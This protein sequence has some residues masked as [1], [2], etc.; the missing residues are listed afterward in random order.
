MRPKIKQIK[1]IKI[2]KNWLVEK[3]YCYNFNFYIFKTNIKIFKVIII[4]LVTNCIKFSCICPGLVEWPQMQ[5]NFLLSNS[6]R[7]KLSYILYQ[8]QSFGPKVSI[9]T[10]AC[11]IMIRA[12]DSLIKGVGWQVSGRN[13]YIQGCKMQG[14]NHKLFWRKPDALSPPRRQPSPLSHHEYLA[15]VTPLRAAWQLRVALIV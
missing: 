9:F 5:T 11:G 3:I 4:T 14:A 12:R 15:A 1:T 7:L 6:K 2:N 13:L 8:I 10:S